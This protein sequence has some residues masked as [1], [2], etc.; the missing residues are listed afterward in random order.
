MKRALVTG[1]AG[2][3]ASH[4][5]DRLLG[6]GCELLLVDDFSSGRRENLAVAS[7]RFGERFELEELDV[8]SSKIDELVGSFKPSVIY[9]LAAQMN[10]RKSV[11]APLFDAQKNIL[12]TVNLLDAAVRHGVDS[13]IFASTGGAI[14]GEQDYFPADE[15]H[16]INPKCPYGV[17]KRAAELY[18]NYYSGAFGLKTVSLRYSN[19]YGPRQNPAGE[20]GVIAIFI[21]NALEG[22]ELRVNGDGEQ[23]RDFVYVDDVVE[24][25]ILASGVDRASSVFNVG[26]GVENSVLDIVTLLGEDE[27]MPDFSSRHMPALA[28]EQRRSVIDSTAIRDALGWKP[29]VAFGDGL[30]KTVESF[31]QGRGLLHR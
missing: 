23:T 26:C 4:L 30:R 14:Y 29:E 25:N 3:I 17:S 7:D 13:F 11:E 18:L 12:G 1:A 5:V 15:A 2:F 9:H 28:G 21:E 8:C 31:S 16:P 20:A 24:A 10:V 6:E 27:H 19:V 22:R